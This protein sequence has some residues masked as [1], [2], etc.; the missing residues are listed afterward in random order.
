MRSVTMFAALL[1]SATAGCAEKAVELRI[2][3]PEG[4]VANMDI[5]CVNS[6][7]VV[8]HNGDL[9]FFGL[10]DACIE[11]DSPT[12]YAD[13]QNQIRGKLDMDLPEDIVA[14]EIRGQANAIPGA[15][16]SGMNVFYAG[17]DYLGSES[18]TLRVEGSMDCSAMT[19]S[20]SLKVRPIDF[21]ALAH[22][23]AD[24]DPVCETITDT[25]GLDLGVIR[26]T[27]ITNPELPSSVV[28]WGDTASLDATGVAI[29]PN[30]GNPLPTSCLATSES[31]DMFSASCIY[32]SH[33]QLC[34]GAGEVEVPLLTDLDSYDSIDNSIIGDYSVLVYGIVYDTTTRR[35]VSGA[36]VTLGEGRGQV[37]YARPTAGTRMEPIQGGATDASG[38]FLAYMREPSVATVTQGGSTK[39]MRI[40]GVTGWGSAVIVP[41]R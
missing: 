21:M 37:V 28:E 5:S 16:G 34:A 38:V 33:R 29:L 18:L 22:T 26:P 39:A 7:H 40:G 13:L 27:N 2:A 35:P 3:W 30:W 20:G 19:G 36:T 12:S 6:V 10:P 32:P 9:D 23:P 14:V 8:I 41:L 24:T 17:A 11:V 31:F 1:A 15:C 25:D 4:D